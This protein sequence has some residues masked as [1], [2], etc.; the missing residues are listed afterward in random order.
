MLNM[1]AAANGAST[2]DAMAWRHRTFVARASGIR[3]TL[4]HSRMDSEDRPRYRAVA[5]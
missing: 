5:E 1:A 2:P 4:N 3:N